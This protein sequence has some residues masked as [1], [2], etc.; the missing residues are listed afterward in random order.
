MEKVKGLSYV[1]DDGIGYKTM[2]EKLTE[3]G[4]VLR[5]DNSSFS[6]TYNKKKAERQGELSINVSMNVDVEYD[7]IVE[8]RVS[9]SVMSHVYQLASASME[10]TGKDLSIKE[11]VRLAET[12]TKTALVCLA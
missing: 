7:S 9:V 10:L 3:L 6:H 1:Y 11:Y 8:F 12:F 4:F 2:K 5:D